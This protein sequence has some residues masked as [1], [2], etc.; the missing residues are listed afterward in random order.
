MRRQAK[1]SDTNEMWLRLALG[2]TLVGGVVS[3]RQVFGLDDVRVATDASTDGLD[4]ALDATAVDAACW[5]APNVGNPC[6]F[7]STDDVVIP[8]A[9]SGTVTFNGATGRFVSSSGTEL[10]RVPCITVLQAS[11]N[12]L[13]VCAMKSLDM[14]HKSLSISNEDGAVAF[15][16]HGDA[17]V[18]SVSLSAIAPDVATKNMCMSTRG[19]DSLGSPAAGAGGSGIGQ[20]GNGGAGASDPIAVGGIAGPAILTTSLTPIITGCRG[21]T[22]GRV[23]GGDFGGSSGTGGGAFEL[24]AAGTITVEGFIDAAGRGGNAGSKSTTGTGGAGGGGGAGGAVL[25]HGAR[26]VLLATAKISA[27]G[28][29]G[30][31]GGGGTSGSTNNSNNLTVARGG[32]G[33]LLSGDGGDGGF[34]LLATATGSHGADAGAADRGAGGGGGGT[35]RIILTAREQDGVVITP[36][37]VIAPPPN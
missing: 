22:G 33:A 36:G 29:G 21:G 35:G 14:S 25:L 3:C 19:A 7:V 5:T 11:N 20:G 32:V 27:N 24:A 17:T 8:P 34:G 1:S 4:D 15:V 16:V 23:T 37:A 12:L 30:G 28:G 10:A 26:V 6:D 2:A 13:R 9:T 31:A 18:N